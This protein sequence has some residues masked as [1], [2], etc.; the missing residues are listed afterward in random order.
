MTAPARI[1]KGLCHCGCG[2]KA[3]VA[4]KTNRKRGWEKGEPLR[5]L[6]GHSG[7]LRPSG[8][9]HFVVDTNTG[10]WNWT[11]SL[12]PTG[13]GHLTINNE[14]V[15]AHRFLY[16]S[17]CGPIPKGLDLDHLCENPRCV[18]PTHLEPVTHAENCRRGKRSKL[19][20]E[21]VAKIRE[22][23]ETGLSHRK[24]AKLFG[25]THTTV[26]QVLRNSAWQEE[27]TDG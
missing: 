27:R 16:E 19:D 15:L 26:G 10:C 2:K 20:W 3:P 24:I 8:V 23:A 21:T 18:N 1:A 14:Q 22:I 13:Y 6:P 9:V 25:V 5:F 17:M 7:R 4:T 11:R 12:M